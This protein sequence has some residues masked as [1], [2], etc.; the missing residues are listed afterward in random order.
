MYRMVAVMMLVVCV[1]SGCNRE[2]K[3]AVQTQEQTQSQRTENQSQAQDTEVDTDGA[4]EDT[5]A[6][7][8]GTITELGT[9]S[10][11][12]HAADEADQQSGKNQETQ[13]VVSLAELKSEV[14]RHGA[15]NWNFDGAAELV[16]KWISQDGHAHPIVFAAD[17]SFQC[18]F[19]WRDGQGNIAK[20]RYA[21]ADS[22][23]VV[24]VA[25]YDGIRIG[26]FFE[27]EGKELVGS[28]GPAP[29]VVW[30]KVANAVD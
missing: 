9:E 16:G 7:S 12:Q 5:V 19:I 13:D 2:S 15:A 6:K 29:R 8:K 3:T 1:G 28:R 27:L 4:A 30:K 22:G 25:R 21:V 24:A 17:G 11:D 23:R 26:E 18:G 10:S 20:G 14:A